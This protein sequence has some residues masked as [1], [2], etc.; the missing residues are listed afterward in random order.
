MFEE[1]MF[2]SLKNTFAA[3]FVAVLLFSGCSNADRPKAVGTMRENIHP[4]GLI[5]KSSENFSAKQTAN[6]FIVE[7]AGGANANLRVPVEIKV[8]FIKD[9]NIESATIQHE[10]S[11]GTRRIR[12]DIGKSEGGSGGETFDFTGYEQV[13]GGTIEYRQTTQSKA[14]EPDFSSLWEI[15]ENTTL[16]K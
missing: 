13:S 5:V 12:Y 11:V 1:V 10:K 3:F 15:I 7:P 4:N 8:D 14:A 2:S 6:G 9:K 16:K